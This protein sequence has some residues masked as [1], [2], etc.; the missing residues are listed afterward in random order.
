MYVVLENLHLDLFIY[1]IMNMHKSRVKENMENNGDLSRDFFLCEQ[2]ICNLAAK[3]I[4]ETYKKYEN[5]AKSI[6][7]CVIENRNKVFFYQEFNVQ[8]EGNLHG[9]NMPFTIGIQTK[10]QKEMMLHHGHES[11]ISI[12][13]TFKTNDKR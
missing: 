4:K 7:M 3:L 11:G 8:V 10:W 12:D 5:D 13:A 1:Q 9:G 6:K 2:D